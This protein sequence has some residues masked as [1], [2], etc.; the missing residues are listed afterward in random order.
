MRELL[1]YPVVIATGNYAF[2]SLVDI[3]SRA[4][5]QVFLST[6]IE[7]GGLSLPPATIGKIFSIFGIFT[8][9]RLLRLR[10][11]TVKAASLLRYV[12]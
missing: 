2:L 3:A 11:A 10:R 12:T 6:S 1:I 5:Q 8:G 7:L 9:R 4:I